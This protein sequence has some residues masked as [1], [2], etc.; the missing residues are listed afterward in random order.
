[1]AKKLTRI[2]KNFLLQNFQPELYLY[3]SVLLDRVVS[4]AQI[5]EKKLEKAIQFEKGDFIKMF[6]ICFFLAFKM[7]EDNYTMFLEDLEELTGF[8]ISMMRKL[9]VALVVNVFQFD[10]FVSDREIRRE[11][12]GLRNIYE[13]LG[14]IFWR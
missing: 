4:K 12:K 6:F 10:I 11:V 14:E 2:F 8:K 3:A 1:M 7:L 13:E 9:E 5:A